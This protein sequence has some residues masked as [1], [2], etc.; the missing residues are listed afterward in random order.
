MILRT[1]STVI[2]IENY[3]FRFKTEYVNT[4][5]FPPYLGI[6]NFP[7][8]VPRQK[9]RKKIKEADVGEVH[10]IYEDLYPSYTHI[11][12]QFEEIVPEF[13]QISIKI[14]HLTKQI[15]RNQH[16]QAI[17]LSKIAFFAYIELNRQ[18]VLQNGLTIS[19]K[20]GS[21]I[22]KETQWNFLLKILILGHKKTFGGPHPPSPHQNGGINYRIIFSNEVVEDIRKRNVWS[23]FEES[24]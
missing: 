14:L 2:G 21:I 18:K 13:E 4:T 23:N 3:N 6:G 17:Q 12:S 8:H 7:H 9:K 15:M 10:P 20:W 5:E 24:S 22:L 19:V 11:C 1:L 16:K